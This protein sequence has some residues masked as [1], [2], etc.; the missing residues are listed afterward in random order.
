M[1]TTA[2]RRRED[3]RLRLQER[4]DAAKTQAYRNRLGQFATPR[5]LAAEIIGCVASLLPPRSKIRFLEPGFGTGPFYSA[6]LR[7]VPPSRVETA[8]GYEV[9]PYYAEPAKELWKGTGLELCIRD[10]TGAEPPKS[11][12]Q[13]FNFVV[14][15]PPYVRHHHLSQAQKHDLQ[16]ALCRYAGIQLNGLS[17]LYT[18]FLVLSKAWMSRNG[19]GAWLIPSE[20]M[21]VNYGRRVKQFLLEDVT[22]H[23]VHRFDPNDVQ[24]GDA[25]VSSA[26]LFLENG[27]PPKDHEVQFSFGGTITAPKSSESIRA[28]DLR[29]VS[30]WTRLPMNGAV[31]RRKGGETLGDLF[32]I[33][34]GV[35]TGSNEF[36]MLAPE[37]IAEWS[38]PD[39]FLTP[40]L[41][42]PRHLET[43][44]IFAG[45]RGDPKIRKRLFLL[46]CDLPE[47][48]VR[49]KHP[50]LY[51]YIRHGIEAGVHER[52]LSRHRDPWYS[53]E[54]RPP[55]PFLCTY[56]GR[57]TKTSDVPFRF[58]LNHSN[59]TAANVYLMLYPSAPLTSILRDA[60]GVARAVW[61][62][63]SSLPAETLIGEGRVYGGGL[64]KLEPRELA[65]VPADPVLRILHDAAGFT[66]D[67]QLQLFRRAKT[68]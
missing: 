11:E 13:K 41:P 51:R 26:V 31:V 28:S 21:D 47:K 2:V 9:D 23:R 60:P 42:S 46:V 64:H 30:K 44:E 24:F 65:N 63:L 39:E 52:Y 7:S 15:N 12:R 36:F 67:T 6:L 55:A 19:V 43:D 61:K 22:L 68:G 66:M 50:A 14:C 27:S 4:L 45:R 59:A 18:Y 48:E 62:V 33:K 53:Q 49:D 40:I 5:E 8:V 34:R 16:A 54:K 56:M 25:L 58:I 29:H 38:L 37:R 32:S 57:A 35:A 17:G 1:T 20:F 10:F 3:A